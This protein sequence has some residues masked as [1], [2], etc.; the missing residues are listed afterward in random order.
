HHAPDVKDILARI[1]EH[2]GRA[3]G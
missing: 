1:L 2:L 3:S